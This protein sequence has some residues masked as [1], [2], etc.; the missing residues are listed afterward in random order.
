MGKK[1][2]LFW[3]RPPSVN[4][5][6]PTNWK[7][8]T[9]F[10]SKKYTEWLSHVQGIVCLRSGQI[11]GPVRVTYTVEPFPDKRRRDL[12]NLVKALSDALV[13]NG[14]IEDDS[15]IIDSRILWGEAQGVHVLVEAA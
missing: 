15:K 9:R 8:K 3:P 11:E 6:Y 2:E 13:A 14:I 4:S 5:L 7:T 12:E 10:K 1:I